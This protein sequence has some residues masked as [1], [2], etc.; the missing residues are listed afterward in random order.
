MSTLLEQAIVDAEAL[1]EAAMK[2]AEASIVEKYSSEVKAAVESL[3]SEEFEEELAEEESDESPVMKDIPYANQTVKNQT[4]KE[5]VTVSLD[6]EALERALNEEGSDE[7]EQTH[8]DLASEVLDEEVEASDDDDKETVTLDVA[9]I[10]EAYGDTVKRQ[11]A[12]ALRKE[13]R[14]MSFQS[15][16]P[17]EH[18]FVSASDLRRQP[19]SAEEDESIDIDETLLAAIAEE[20]RVDVGMPGQGMGGRTTPTSADLEGQEATLANLKDDELAEEHE[21]LQKAKEEADMY[22]EQVKKLTASNKKLQTALTTLN[23]RME[24]VNLS[25][26]RLLYTNRVLKSN[27]LNERQRTRIVESIST[28]GSVEEAKVIYD[29][30][31]SAVGG[32]KRVPQSLSEAVD[33]SSPTLPRNSSRATKQPN[34]Q[35]PQY[36][37]MRALAGIKGDN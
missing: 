21:A 9:E 3:L 12:R 18:E 2:N 10:A 24:D 11:N 28:A 15:A 19:S 20:L 1:R 8:E 29:T 27:S 5:P 37:R 35:S 33:R 26:A 6:L 30:L 17:E 7:A 31:Q 36:N 25:N 14:P 13:P 22:L 23:E 34:A 4:G 32:T 16:D